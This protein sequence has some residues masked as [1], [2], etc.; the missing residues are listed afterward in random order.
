[1]SASPVSQKPAL[2]QIHRVGVVG[3]GVMGSGIA[4]WLA[5]HGFDVVLRDVSRE[6]LERGMVTV[7][8]LF[9]GA[10]KRGK[11]APGAGNSGLHRII[12]TTGWDGFAACDLVIEAIV[13]NARAK[14]ILFSEVATVVRP[15]TILASNTSALPIEEIAGHVRNPERTIGMHFFNPVSRMP[16]VEVI[17]GKY[18]SAENVE[19]ALGLTKTLGKA[20]IICRSSPGFLVTRVL[21]FY[22]NEAVRL[23]EQ[24]Y[25]TEQI[26]AEMREF[27]WPMGRCA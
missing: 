10:V 4:Q 25:S 9:D 3:A 12:T 6:V 15:D 23:R 1:M 17:V 27:G 19:R 21:F 11:L 26:D 7:R 2:P 13:E 16:L 22:L 14:Q 24:G 20:A 8:E 5:A 18:T